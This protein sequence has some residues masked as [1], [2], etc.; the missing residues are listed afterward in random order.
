[1]ESFSISPTLGGRIMRKS[2]D[3][4]RRKRL[5]DN[6]LDG[7]TLMFLFALIWFVMWV[8]SGGLAVG[9]TCDTRPITVQ[10]GDTL[11]GIVREFC[12]GTVTDALDQVVRVYGTTIYPNTMIYL[13]SSDRCTLT[14][15][16]AGQVYE[17]CS[18]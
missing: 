14:L 7:L 6:A 1:M 2:V 16:D 3:N 8:A 17:N 11:D 15:D 4:Y 13:P 10:S 5:G 18:P 9:F 12:A